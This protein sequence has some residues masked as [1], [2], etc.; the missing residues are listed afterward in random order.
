MNRGAAEHLE[1]FELL[2]GKRIALLTTMTIWE[3]LRHVGLRQY[4]E[5]G[6]VGVPGSHN[7]HDLSEVLVGMTGAASIPQFV[8]AAL[9]GHH[10]GLIS[11]KYIAQVWF[12]GAEIH[13]S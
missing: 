4:V 3:R 6:G 8:E 2:V 1:I 10:V 9:E 12:W 13:L 11:R 5:R 7:R